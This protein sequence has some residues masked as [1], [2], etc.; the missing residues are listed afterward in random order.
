VVLNDNSAS[1]TA[2]AWGA[3]RHAALARLLVERVPGVC[4]LVHCGPGDRDPARAIVAQA[5]HPRVAGLGDVAELPLGL[6]KAVYRRAALSV[7]S[8]SGPRHIAAAFGVPTVAILGPTDP[9]LGRSDEIRCVEVRKP[10]VCSPCN[11]AV[12]PL[13]HHDCMRLITV[14]EVGQAALETLARHGRVL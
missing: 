14:E 5:A 7:S 1:G 3:E 2:R 6:S 12:C 10:L 11:E 8:D 4:V 13:G 9:L